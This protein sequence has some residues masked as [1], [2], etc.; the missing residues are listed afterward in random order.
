[1]LG[2]PARWLQG[3][4]VGAAAAKG[5]PQSTCWL[6]SLGFGSSNVMGLLLFGPSKR[7]L[8][9][10]TEFQIEMVSSG[11]RVGPPRLQCWKER[12]DESIDPSIAREQRHTARIVGPHCSEP[13]V[14]LISRIYMVQNITWGRFSSCVY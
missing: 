2:T 7:P 1:M 14:T 11:N 8:L 4:G 9:L 13:F 10:R 3:S 12:G 6:Y 5:W